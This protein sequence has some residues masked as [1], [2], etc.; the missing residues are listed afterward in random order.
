MTDRTHANKNL[1]REFHSGIWVG[2]LELFDEHVAD[3]YVGHDPNVP[4]NL[5][6]PEEFREF[7][8]GFQVSMS[9]IERTIAVFTP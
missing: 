2:N 6:G 7:I 4:E 5:H 9:D 1:V 3:D 8:G